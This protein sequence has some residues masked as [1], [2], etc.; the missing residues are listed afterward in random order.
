MKRAGEHVDISQ[1]G[2]FNTITLDEAKAAAAKN[3]AANKS[4]T[5]DTTNFETAD[6]EAAVVDA[7][8]PQAGTCTAPATR[9][10][11]RSLS[12]ADQASFVQAV[13][14][15]INLPPSG[16]FASAGSGNRY[17]DL[18]AVHLQMTS[19][20]HMFPQFLPWHR[21]YVSIFES[22]L[23]EECSYTA[24]LP[25]WNEE[26]DAGHFSTA[27]L[28]TTSSFGSAPLKTSDGQ[29]TCID[30]VRKT[31]PSVLGQKQC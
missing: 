2:G 22:M 7:A 14:C 15:L 25:W 30:G 1:F 24:P 18:V 17:E 6:T 21:Y 4:G 28:F 19:T 26:L 13:Q 23:R 10:E 3:N 27:P 16:A 9:I 31:L 20:I 12:A 11:W 5:T 8:T 29:G